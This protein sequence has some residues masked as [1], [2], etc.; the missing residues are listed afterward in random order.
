MVRRGGD[1]ASRLR[2]ATVHSLPEG[3]G[4]SG[5]VCV[6][7]TRWRGCSRRARGAHSGEASGSNDAR[8]ATAAPHA[9]PPGC[10]AVDGLRTME[11]W[12]AMSLR[13]VRYAASALAAHRRCTAFQLRSERAVAKQQ[14]EAIGNVGA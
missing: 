7:D 9:A 6:D 8:R 5:W 14:G 2:L 13:V 3:H 11:W 1:D 12:P 10:A 4:R